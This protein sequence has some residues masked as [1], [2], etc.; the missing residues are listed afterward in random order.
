MQKFDYLTSQDPKFFNNK[1]NIDEMNAILIHEFSNRIG[2]LI[3][4]LT[5]QT[6]QNTMESVLNHGGIC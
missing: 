6:F 5:I 3:T 2:A 1:R 4:Y